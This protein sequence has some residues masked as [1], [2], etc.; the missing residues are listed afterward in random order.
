[1]CIVQGRNEVR[2]RLGQ[3]VSLASPCSNLRSFGNKCTVLKSACDIVVTFWPPTVIRGKRNCASFP[4]WLRFWC[5]AIKIGRLSENKKISSPM[6]MNVWSMNI[7][8][9][10]TQYGM[11]L[12]QTASKGN[13]RHFRFLRVNLC[14]FYACSTRFLAWT[15]VVLQVIPL[16]QHQQVCFFK[17]R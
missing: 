14:H 12:A 17:V 9:F 3:E 7:C 4:P 6:V 8:N 13:Q 1:M 10:Q 5:Y 11:D 2:W 15:C 16:F